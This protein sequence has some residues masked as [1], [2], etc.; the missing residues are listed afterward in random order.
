[1]AESAQQSPAL[2]GTAKHIILTGA[3]GYI[4]RHLMGCALAR[5][6]R[7]TVLS[8]TRP[9]N[10][11]EGA[12][13]WVPWSLGEALPQGAL[14]ATADFPLADAVIHLAHQWV[15]PTKGASAS[16]SD[17]I[18]IQGTRL[19]HATARQLGIARFVFASSVSSRPDALNRYGRIKWQVERMLDLPDVVS[20]RVGLVYGGERKGLWGTLT[21]LVSAIPVLPMID[22]GHPNQPI[23]IDDLCEGFF[24]LAT[25][26]NPQ[27]RLFVLADPQPVSFGRFLTLIARETYGR[28]LLVV[29]VP[30]RPVLLA[31][32][33]VERAIALP[34]MI[35]ERIYGLAGIRVLDSRDDLNTLNLQLRPL[36]RGLA[37]ERADHRKALLL[38]AAIVL[39]Y[40]TGNMPGPGPLR[41]YVRGV[42]RYGDGRTVSMPLLA[43]VYPSLLG[44]S[45]PLPDRQSRLGKRLAFGVRLAETI[46]A[47]AGRMYRYGTTA[48][49]GELV[50]L[51][52]CLA[53]EALLLPMRMI[54]G[55]RR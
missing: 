12:W 48:S 45:E 39:R 40:L 19:L 10:A 51:V 16:E 37:E 31:L 43:R 47:G 30:L 44:I 1:M 24:R 32:D 18:N 8:R 49:G 52:F 6:W 34:P 9:D 13:R 5:G 25:T 54:F 46:P 23:H 20:A 2:S 22:A 7:V 29:P 53:V 36:E 27:R 3:T 11:Q 4:G 35:R 21:R 41:R 50:S 33:A 26:E 17:D 14:A 15:S 28:F 42:V 38:E 55:S